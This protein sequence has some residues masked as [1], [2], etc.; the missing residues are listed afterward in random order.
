[1][2]MF[3]I[4]IFTTK[5]L[6]HLILN[7]TYP[8]LEGSSEGKSILLFG[9]MGS[10]LLLYPL[11]RFNG[12]I[13]KKISSLNPSFQGNGN[14]YLKLLIIVVLLTYL[15][16]IIIEIIIRLKLGVSIFTTF[17]AMDPS[18]ASTSITHSHVFKSVLG[19]LISASGFHVPSN[20][21]TGS[22]LIHY[23]SPLSFVVL[24]SFP[25]VYLLGL[26]SLNQR[27]NRY[28]VILAF[29]ITTSLIGMLDGG[30]FSTPALIGLSG[31][32]GVYVIKEPF[33]RRDFLKPSFLIIL[34]I[35]LRISIEESKEPIRILSVTSISRELADNPVSCRIL[36]IISIMPLCR[37]WTTDI[38]TDITISSYPICCSFIPIVQASLKTHSPIGMINPVSS[39]T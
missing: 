15:L 13:M 19:D 35:L 31:L 25:L 2:I 34:L 27:K 30:L 11:F 21:H 9:I 38:L 37:S 28:K 5:F 4:L 26:I 18:P 23:T 29:A 17:V 22:S 8:F 1:M 24:I 14:K 36:L 3:S 33:S 7:I 12:I 20:I 6:D 10:I 32:L 16:G 39:A